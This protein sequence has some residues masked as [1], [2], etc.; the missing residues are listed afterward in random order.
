MTEY[1]PVLNKRDFVRRYRLGEFGNA[2]PT[3]DTYEEWEQDCCRFPASQNYHIRNRVAS[4]QTWYNI[5]LTVM[6][7]AWSKAIESGYRASDLYISAM[8]PHQYNLLQGEVQ[9]TY[10]GLSLFY[11]DQ[12]GVPMRT[13]L[14]SG[15][16]VKGL[17]ATS[18]LKS[19]LCPNSWDWLNVLLDWYP[20]H[21]VE[22]S[23][24]SIN[25]GTLPNFNTVF[26]EVRLGY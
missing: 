15:V 1:R 18:L 24:F 23:T 11:S 22:F 4:A 2:S 8:A 19:R 26:W 16:S 7:G 17:A 12:V 13:A 14:E 9:Q 25:W 10:E 6:P 5:S 20:G 3:W 21:V